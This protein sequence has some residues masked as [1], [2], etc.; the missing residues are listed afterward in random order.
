MLRTEAAFE[1]SEQYELIHLLTSI[2][3]IDIDKTFQKF[4]LLFH[5]FHSFYI[6][7]TGL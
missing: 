6:M 2:D 3:K 1:R 4:L 5:F 7:R